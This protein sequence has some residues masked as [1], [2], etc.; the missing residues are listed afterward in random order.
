MKKAWIICTVLL[1]GVM[2]LSSG[3]NAQDPL[4]PDPGGGGGGGGSQCQYCG[5]NCCDP[6]C[7]CGAPPEGHAFIGWCGCSSSSCYRQ[8]AYT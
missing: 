1:L 4:N 6:Y 8:C 7:N 5:G 2:F 3:T